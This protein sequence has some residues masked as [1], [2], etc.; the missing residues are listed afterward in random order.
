MHNY[1]KA[2]LQIQSISDPHVRLCTVTIKDPDP[3][4]RGRSHLQSAACLVSPEVCAA[5]LGEGKE[6]RRFFIFFAFL[7]KMMSDVCIYL[8]MMVQTWSFLRVLFYSLCAIFRSLMPRTICRARNFCNLGLPV[9]C[10][11]RSII[12]SMVDRS[13]PD[14]ATSGSPICEPRTRGSRMNVS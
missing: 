12:S 3:R 9:S 2:D 5:R 7:C 4:A 13:W 14:A 10:K 8:I 11:H 1:T 6:V